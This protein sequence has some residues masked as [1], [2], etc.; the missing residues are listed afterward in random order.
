MT[1][2]DGA[3]LAWRHCTANASRFYMHS[4]I[5]QTLLVLAGVTYTR[6]VYLCCDQAYWT[7][8]P[9]DL[10]YESMTTSEPIYGRR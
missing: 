9:A 3:V 6:A 2:V 4:I 5:F 7:Q 1:A 10:Q 8:T